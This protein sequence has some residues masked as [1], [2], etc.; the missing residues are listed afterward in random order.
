MSKYEKF[1]HLCLSNEMIFVC[2]CYF[3]QAGCDFIAMVIDVHEC[4]S[5]I[6]IECFN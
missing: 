4:L 3:T 2:V 1:D 5:L 6:R